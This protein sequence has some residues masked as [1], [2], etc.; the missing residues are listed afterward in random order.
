MTIFKICKKILFIIFILVLALNLACSETS[1]EE[2]AI[3]TVKD[4]LTVDIVGSWKAVKYEAGYVVNFEDMAYWYV[5]DGKVSSLNGFA[6]TY[7]K[8]TEFKYGIP[9]RDLF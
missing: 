1:I 9:F 6:G 7:A 5:E 3:E 4:N 2:K 8:N